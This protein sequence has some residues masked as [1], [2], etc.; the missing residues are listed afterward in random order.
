MPGLEILAFRLSSLARRACQVAVAAVAVTL[1]LAVAPAGA[2][3]EVAPGLRVEVVAT[4]LPRP[5]HVDIDAAGRVVVLSH[6]WRG[7]AAAEIF[8]LDPRGLPI[9]A[10]RV[11]RVVVPFEA[12]RKVAFGS[13]AI[14]PVSGDLFLGE[15]NGNRVYRLA[16]PGKLTL[17]GTGL[18]HL[19]GGSALAF[20]PAGRLVAIDYAS[21]DAQLRSERPPPPGLEWLA[22]EAYHGPIVIRLDP[23][24]DLALPRQLDLVPPVF[25]RAPA[26][27][28][29]IEPLFR[30]VS[31][32]VAPDGGLVFLTSVGEI[33]VVGS[34]GVARRRVRLPSGHYHRT[35]M[36]V[37]ADGSVY[38]NSGFHIRLLYRVTPAGAVT[39]VARE[40]GDP[41]GIAVDAAGRLYVAEGALHRIIRIVPG[42]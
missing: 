35:H 11:P 40:L 26:Q 31:V 20:D 15:E 13:L 7:D 28:A 9:D 29:G 4:G 18:N 36:T 24:D 14:D 34:D 8:R 27:R 12:P 10:S 25:P 22:G 1:A 38:V 3:V 30:F 21:P 42:P 6:G 17:F 2:E 16:T 32:A 33:L 23:R 39:T 19:V 5:V 37:G 41:G